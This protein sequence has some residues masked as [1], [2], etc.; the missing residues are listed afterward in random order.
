MMF[1]KTILGAAGVFAMAACAEDVGRPQEF[2]ADRDVLCSEVFLDVGYDGPARLYGGRIEEQ[3]A[4][5]NR[6]ARL[7][8]EALA[9]DFAVRSLLTDSDPHVAGGPRSE[10][11]VVGDAASRYTAGEIVFYGFAVFLPPN[12]VDDG[13]N[14]D[15]VFQWK[16]IADP[17]EPGKSPDVFL[18]VKRDEFV[19]RITSDANAIST[20]DSPLKEQI[21]LVDGVDLKRGGWHE[22]MFHMK[23][24]YRSDGAITALYRGPGDAAYAN[25]GVHNGPNMHND[26]LPGYLKWGIYKPSWKSG[27]TATKQRIVYHDNIR[28]G[29]DWSV[30]RT[31][32]ACN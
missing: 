4:N 16:N 13:G 14:E 18:A 32:S 8:L 30:V 6:V 23:W 22:F 29:S 11:Q 31:D 5:P 21:G 26:Q 1:R 7:D 24:S 28:A 25:V 2:G 20:A 27:T 10:T 15:I 3:E 9:G 17:G 12:W 19:L